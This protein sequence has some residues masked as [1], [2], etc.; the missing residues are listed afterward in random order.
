MYW[1]NTMSQ[2]VSQACWLLF[3][4]LCAKMSNSRLGNMSNDLND[5]P[6]IRRSTLIILEFLRNN[7]IWKVVARVWV[8]FKLNKIVTWLLYPK[9]SFFIKSIIY[10]L[11]DFLNTRKSYFLYLA[12]E[13]NCYVIILVLGTTFALHFMALVNVTSW[14]FL[15]YLY[16]LFSNVSYRW[17]NKIT[18]FYAITQPPL[19]NVYYFLYVWHFSL[20]SMFF[21]INQ[22]TSPCWVSFSFHSFLHP[23]LQVLSSLHSLLRTELQVLS[24]L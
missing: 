20:H 8:M 7:N 15:F 19:F 22:F 16:I 10:L 11:E 9:H 24:S 2:P 6:S 21:Y 1:W 23:G 14:Y 4:K 3:R 12:F 13:W 17:S 18:Y 5:K